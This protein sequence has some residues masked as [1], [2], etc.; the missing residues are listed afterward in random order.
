MRD[1]GLHAGQRLGLR[2]VDA[3]DARVRVRAAQHRAV[4]HALQADVG[5]VLGAPVTLSTPSGRTGRVPMTL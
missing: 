4:E 1:H 5:A 2:G 3:L